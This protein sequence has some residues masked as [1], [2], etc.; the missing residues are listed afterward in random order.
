MKRSANSNSGTS[1]TLK[2][3]ITGKVLVNK[4]KEGFKKQGIIIIFIFVFFIISISTPYFLTKRNIINILR[5]VSMV[6]IIGCGMTFVLLL[7]EIDLS[8]GSMAS[9][10]GVIAAFLQVVKGAN[11]FFAISLSISVTFVLGIGMGFIITKVKV[12]SFIVTLGMLSSAKAV[13]LIISRGHPIS[14]LQ[15]SFRFIGG[16]MAGPIPVPFILFIV[17]AIFSYMILYHTVFG[18]YVYSIGGNIETARLSG[19]PVDRTKIIVFGI[20]GLMAGI[21]GIILAARINSGQ[22]IAGEGLLFEAITAVVIGGTSL[23]GGIG[24]IG[25]TVVGVFLLGIIR[26]GLNLIG[27]SPFWQKVFNGALIILVVVLDRI[28][29]RIKLY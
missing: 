24:G 27:V 23:F 21:S 13:A 29:R 20:S 9:L 11:T 17:I 26:N 3:L 12:H 16:G 22:S 4:V 6:G 28:R 2:R 14:G 1:A 25:G 15:R 18:K 8:V 19:I 5:Q 10:V 7:A